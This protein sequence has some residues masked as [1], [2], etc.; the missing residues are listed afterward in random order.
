MTINSI[1]EARE[2][3]SFFDNGVALPLGMRA[4]KNSYAAAKIFLSGWKAR[5]EKDVNILISSDHCD[6]EGHKCV[7]EII[8]RIQKL[9][10]EVKK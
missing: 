5:G 8:E 1:E 3:I 10:E 9:D 6:F 4:G 7:H 2:I